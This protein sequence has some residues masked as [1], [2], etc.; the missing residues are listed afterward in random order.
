MDTRLLLSVRPLEDWKEWIEKRYI[1]E[2]NSGCWLWVGSVDKGGYARVGI[3]KKRF[4]VHRIVFSLLRGDIPAGLVIDHLCRVPSCIN[5]QH[6]ETVTIA[7]NV[8][9]GRSANRDKIRYYG[10]DGPEAVSGSITA[11]VGMEFFC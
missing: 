8:V 6:M 5:P 9:R 10:A 11:I 4:F 2:P 7:E 1:P 3:K